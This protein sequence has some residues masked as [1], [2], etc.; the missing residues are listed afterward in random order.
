MNL[1]NLLMIRDEPQTP[2]MWQRLW[3][4]AASLL[5]LGLWGLLWLS[6]SP[7]S[8]GEIFHPG[9]L[10]AL[11]NGLRSIFPFVAA[12]LAAVL[13]IYKLIRN[14]PR[15]FRF[16]SPLGMATI[17]GLVGVLAVW[18]SPDSAVALRWVALYLS[19]PLVLWA[20]VWGAEPLEQIR[21]IIRITWLAMT[22]GT[23][24]LFAIAMFYLDLWNVLADP[25][26]LLECKDG[27]WNDLT[28]GRLRSTGVG[29]Y[30]AIAAIVAISGLWQRSWRTAWAT[31]LVISVLLLLYSG[32]RGA[33]GGFVVG[34]A[35]TVLLYGGRRALVAGVLAMVVLVPV[36]WATSADDAFLDNCVFR[37]VQI[38]ALAPTPVQ[39]QPT[40]ILSDQGSRRIRAEFFEFTGRSAVWAEALRLV[41]DSPILGYGFHADRL[42][43]GTHAHNAVVHSLIQTGVAGTLPFLGALLFAWLSLIRVTKRL[44]SL[45]ITHKHL[46]IQ[47]GGILAFLSMRAFPESTGAFF[48]VDWLILA[49][50]LLYLHLVASEGTMPPSPTQ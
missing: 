29:R 7:G 45:P 6:V 25:A 37:T 28:S 11:I 13:L 49:P 48:G 46:V 44:N 33:F 3:P 23:I 1:V 50:L 19:V 17:Y 42:L 34:A 26:Q 32:A 12:S 5:P 43:L 21:R 35:M 18:K 20:V 27:G 36:F 10:T 38:Q 41:R 31:V 22:L 39:D 30:A 4:Y 24:A 8:T 47:S 40:E 16:L 14:Y 9:S 15:G 2:Y